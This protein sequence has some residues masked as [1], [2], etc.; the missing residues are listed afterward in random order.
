[1]RVIRNISVWALLILGS[2]FVF[3]A[4]I[5]V[6]VERTIFDTDTFVATV[7]RILEDE[8]VRQAIAE[9]FSAQ[10]IEHAEVEQ[11]IGEGL[12]EGLGFVSGPVTLA[13]TDLLT[14]ASLRATE[15]EVVRTA[16]DEALRAVHGT[17][18]A[19]IEDDS[20]TLSVQGD[21]LVLNL[22]PALESVAE[23]VGVAEGGLLENI[24]LP[25]EAGQFAIEDDAVAWSYR[26]LRYGRGVVTA[27]S[28]AAVAALALSVAVARERRKALRNVGIV[29]GVVGIL[30]LVL[31]L[32]LRQA[33]CGGALLEGIAGIVIGRPAATCGE[34]DGDERSRTAAGKPDAPRWEYRSHLAPAHRAPS[35]SPQCI[36]RGSA[37]EEPSPPRAAIATISRPKNHGI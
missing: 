33:A 31:L 20:G 7:D 30:S 34:R 17:L 15:I 36:D 11:R 14:E 13:V 23:D 24:E 29:L 1:M 16:Q 9:D 10:L 4:N 2:L 37:C 28:I 6:W 25:E 21:K 35:L 26:I 5:G 22:R 27:V 8:S 12:P 3:S 18:I 32:P 19:I